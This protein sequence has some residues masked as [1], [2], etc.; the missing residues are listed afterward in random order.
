MSDDQN[1]A[2]RLIGDWLGMRYSRT[3]SR[4]ELRLFLDHDGRYEWT[5]SP[6]GAPVRREA[7]IW[8]YDAD[9]NAIC[10]APD[11]NGRSSRWGIVSIFGNLGLMLRETILA[12]PNLP[13][14]FQRVGDRELDYGTDWRKRKGIPEIEKDPPST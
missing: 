14:I 3:G 11:D 4:L 8:T 7:G 12:T 9:D 2:Q 1:S 10:F 6:E 5:Q 13:V